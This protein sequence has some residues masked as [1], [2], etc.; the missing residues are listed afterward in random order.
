MKLFFRHE[1]RVECI[2]FGF[3][4][5]RLIAKEPFPHVPQVA[6]DDCRPSSN[7]SLHALL[8]VRARAQIL[9]G[10]NNFEDEGFTAN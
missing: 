3:T 5:N 9:V 8:E 2:E 10:L 1:Q 4:T 7:L 6:I